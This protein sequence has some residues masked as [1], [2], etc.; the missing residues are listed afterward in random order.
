MEL[1]SNTTETIAGTRRPHP[2]SEE[3]RFMLRAL[4]LAEQGRRT[5]SPNP[6][7]GAVVVESGEIAG[8]GFHM[9]A[10]EPHAEVHAIEQAG[11]KARGATM[12]VTLEPC[13]H[14]GRTPPCADLVVKAGLS[15]VVVAM[16]DP[17]PLVAGAGAALM[18]AAGIE[19]VDGPY[20]AIAARQNESFIKWI[21]TGRPFVTLKMAMSLDGK[22][23]TRTGD[24][25]WVSSEAS[26]RDVHLERARSDAVMVGVGTVLAD[27]PQLTARGV[28]AT[29]QP[30]RVIVDSSARTPSESKVCDTGEAQTLLS[31][32]SEAETETLDLMRG[33]G[34][35][36]FETAGGRRVDLAMLLEELGGR[37]VTRVLAEGGPTLAAALCDQGLVDKLVFY[38]APRLVGGTEAPGPLGGEGVALMS[39]A[40]GA[41]ID[42]VVDLEPDLKI[43]A[44]PTGRQS[45]SQE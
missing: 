12:Y 44:Y 26:R 30:L 19:V 36:V 22:V 4:D 45:C 27:D 20:G 14:Q 35:E 15:R 32:G 16:M 5:A 9:R 10:G 18:A 21:A 6:V 31:V 25:K 42:T 40:A 13:S 43:V 2:A 23:A 11:A 38:V 41:R 37:Q 33:L 39:S 29:R 8:E 34:V 17:N 28:G 1:I 3:E 7:V 24:S